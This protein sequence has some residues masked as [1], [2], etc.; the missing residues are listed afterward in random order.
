MS[1]APSSGPTPLQSSRLFARQETLEGP[2]SYALPV[3]DVALYLRRMPGKQSD[4]EDSAG[5]YPLGET[6]CVLAVADGMGG[7]PCGAEAA[8]L[9][10]QSLAEGLTKGEG[11]GAGLRG[12]ILDSIDLASAAIIDI[13]VGAG[14]T[15]AVVEIRNNI[16]R[17]Y[18]AG[19]SEIL[20]VGQRGRIKWQTISHSPVGYAVEAGLLSPQE[21]LHH[22]ERHLLS[23]HLGDA[24]LRIELGPPVPLARHDTVLI[25]SD[26]LFDNLHVAEL[27][28]LIRK[29]S[30]SR[31]AAALETL[32]VSR[33]DGGNADHPSK[34][35]DVGFILFRRRA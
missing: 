2:E 23:N 35:D 7:M 30:L 22:D 20:V 17:A 18:H 31:V 28:E 24:D 29:G 5:L 4:I 26:G 12:T 10:V 19:D 15:I 3:G 21:A 6:A 11:T 13:G 16:L 25:A 34:P 8:T 1:R 14:A 9:A 33:M 32:I 27:I